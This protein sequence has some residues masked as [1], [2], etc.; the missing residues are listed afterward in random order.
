MKLTINEAMVLSKHMRGRY[1]EL[2]DLRRTCSVKETYFG[3]KE[4]VVEPQYPMKMLDRR[5]VEIEN[6]LLLVDTKIKQSN[7]VTTIEIEGDAQEL[8]L[9]LE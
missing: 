5:C 3:E 2:S 1:S 9:P 7:A 4:K 8:M 6:F